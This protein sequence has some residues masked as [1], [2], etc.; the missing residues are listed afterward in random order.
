MGRE[1]IAL[2]SEDMN[3]DFLAD[4]SSDP[5]VYQGTYKVIIADDDGEVHAITKLM[6]QSFSFKGRELTFI[7]TYSGKETID[8]LIRNPDTAVLL[9]DVVMEDNHAGLFVVD[10]LRN[11]LT[12]YLTRI[13]LRTG[14]PGEAPEDKV[15]RDYDIN[16]YRLKTE[17]TVQRLTTSMYTALRS[18]WDM[19]QLERNRRGLEKMIRV[20]SEMFRHKS[21][22]EFLTSIL[23][24][25]A[26]FT[27]D[28][29]RMKL[30]REGSGNKPEW[31]ICSAG[32][33][34]FTILAAQGKYEPYVNQYLGA[35]DELSAI[36]HHIMDS[37]D[38]R[39]RV[40]VVDNGF[41]IRQNG[42]TIKNVMFVEGDKNEFDLDLLN[43]F[44]SHYSVA[45]D[46]FYLNKLMSETQVEIIY[47]LGEVVEAY[48]EET[49]GHQ[50]RIANLMRAMAQKAGFSDSMAEFIRYASALHDVGKIGIPNGILKKPGQL[51]DEEMTVMKTH[52]T[53]GHKILAKTNL[54]IFQIAADIA[55]H[56][57][58]KFDGTGYPDGLAG[59]EISIYSR[60][61]AIVDVFDA[62]TNKRVYKD[63][64]SMEETLG[65]LES[66]KGKHFDPVLVDIFIA[67]VDSLTGVGQD[68]VRE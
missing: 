39:S 12:N 62:M 10:Y 16:D 29:C 35:V 58:E 52:S 5:I 6:L 65:F 15:I 53:I 19:V 18:Y 66:Q 41:I 37:M 11:T 50:K 34:S 43:L 51:T 60:L 2:C 28:D 26:G 68:E 25:I 48:F 22:A 27:S 38:S 20:S 64:I 45:L 4:A 56:H 30:G 54:E 55:L 42:S 7:D 36:Y 44:L 57:H 13:I 59:D 63:A 1:K 47:T 46:N 61:M 33:T 21:L 31:F 17:L 24:Q 23:E 40:T 32:K 14:Q 3:L 67:N 9:L 8:A 49:S